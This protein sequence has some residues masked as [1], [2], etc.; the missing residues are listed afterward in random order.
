MK[1]HFRLS[2]RL[3]RAGF[4]TAV[5]AL[6]L[7]LFY[8]LNTVILSLS[9]LNTW[10]FYT[11]T[12][13]DLT[14]SGAASP[15][16]SEI[17]T[18]EGGIK[19]IFC[20]SRVNIT[21]HSQ[22]DFVHETVTGLQT[23]HPD[24]IEISYVNLWLE[25]AKLEPYRYDEEGEERTITSSSVIVDYRGEHVV[26]S[27]E[28]F[29]ILD[30]DAYVTSYN[31]EEVLVASML[32]V[33]A[34]THKTAY[35]TANHGEEIPEALY[36]LLTYSGYYVERL[37]LST[38][39]AV[40]EDAGMVVISSPIYDFQRAADVSSYISELK[41]LE[42][43]LAEGGTLF[44]SVSP[45]YAEGLP[46]LREFLL[47]YGLGVQDGTLVDSTNAL[48]GSLGYTIFLDY[49]SEGLGAQL[50]D[51]VSSGN[52]RTLL[53][54]AMALSSTPVD[55]AHVEV[56]L[57]S[58]G[59]A[60]LL[61]AGGNRIASG[62]QPVMA[63]STLNEGGG[64]ILLTGSAYLA[65]SDAVNSDLYA[66]KSL[67]YSLFSLFGAGRTPQGIPAVAVDRSAI[68]NLTKGE[69]DF[70][71]VTVAAVVPCAVL[72]SGLIICRRRKNH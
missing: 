36:R 20:D 32:W 31:G 45:S 4:M 67:L 1:K 27:P 16:L 54:Q 17:D 46:R 8:L 40:P 6:V 10:Y 12:Q 15:L 19:I 58:S 25:P 24:L 51:K 35:F 30:S 9:E 48:P 60:E 55:R 38:V 7:A 42:N 29:Y 52:R 68:E 57:R 63:M 5:T 28:D 13:Y 70:F 62:A 3:D 37:D 56:L 2:R 39:T 49:A 43:Y 61:D 53:S 47:G 26:H 59:S 21:A 50:A 23:L 22:L 44:A 14:P 65:A 64:R 33:S 41:K 34:K 72:V 69:A 11:T 18:E 71:T 66:N